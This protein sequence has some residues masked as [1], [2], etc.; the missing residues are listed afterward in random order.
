MKKKKKLDEIDFSCYDFSAETGRIWS[1]HWKK[2]LPG[3]K[4]KIKGNDDDYYLVVELKKKDGMKDF[5]QYHRVIAY[6]FCKRP[7]QFKDVPY[8]LLEVNHKNE[9]K[10][11]N[12]A[13]NLEWCDRPYN[14]NY[15][16]GNE[17][18]SNTNK[19]IVHTSEW[20][21]K[22]GNALSRPLIQIK[23]NGEIV[24]WESIA[25]ANEN[26]YLQSAV[27]QCCNNKFH[28][29]KNVKSHRRYKKSYWYFKEDYTIIAE[30]TVI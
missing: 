22:V 19:A 8:E 15:G 3:R 23:D 5:Y 14:V 2:W 28:M 7:E 13:S 18:R 6:L 27:S 10:Y 17:K 29:N 9:V 30:T 1:K 11:D 25:K 26:G 16:T 20:N 12:R 21:S 4:A 24:E